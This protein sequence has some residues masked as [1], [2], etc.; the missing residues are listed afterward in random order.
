MK[1]N[2][3]FW[4]DRLSLDAIFDSIVNRSIHPK[5]PSILYH[6]T[7]WCGA[8]GIVSSQR[9]HKTAHDCTNDDHELVAAHE[10]ITK[11]AQRLQKKARGAATR[12]LYHFLNAYE[13]LQ[14]N[15]M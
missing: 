14:I 7:N 10:V 9:F 5:A 8:E 12:A 11:V 15:K 1:K 3:G 13:R 6:Y 2:S 4:R